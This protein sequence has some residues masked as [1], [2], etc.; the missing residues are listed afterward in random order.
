MLRTP[1]IRKPL[2]GKDDWLG[3]K[4]DC[5]SMTLPFR[6]ESSLSRCTRTSQGTYVTTGFTSEWEHTALR[7]PLPAHIL[8]YGLGGGG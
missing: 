5:R 1:R 2:G 4:D 6:D 7:A 3:G 8:T